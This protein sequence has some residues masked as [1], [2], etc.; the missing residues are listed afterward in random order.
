MSSSLSPTNT[1]TAKDGPMRKSGPIKAPSSSNNNHNLLSNKPTYIES[2]R[3]RFLVMD[4]PSDSNLHLYI[5]EMQ[6]YHVTDVV[7]VCLP[8]YSTDALKQ[9]NIITHVRY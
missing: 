7:R 5:K 8:T 1:A 9:I 4:A 6:R 3:L 2:G